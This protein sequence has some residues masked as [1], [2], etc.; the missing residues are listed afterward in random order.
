MSLEDAAL[1][2]DAAV[3]EEVSLALLVELQQQLGQVAGHFHVYTP[4]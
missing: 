1:D 3:T 2:E 4:W